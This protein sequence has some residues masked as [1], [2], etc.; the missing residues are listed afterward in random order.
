MRLDFLSVGEE[1]GADA[2]A[3]TLHGR[4]LRTS[5]AVR[6]APRCCSGAGALDRISHFDPVEHSTLQIADVLEAEAGKDRRGRGAPHAGTADRDQLSF[7]IW[8]Q[9][10]RAFGQ[11]PQRNQDAARDVAEL[12]SEFVRLAHVEQ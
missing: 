6:G 8:V 9:L 10:L 4:N 11:M 3:N 12:A 1:F 7:F 5:R 2:W